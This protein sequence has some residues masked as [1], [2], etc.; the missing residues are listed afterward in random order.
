VSSPPLGVDLVSA[1][2]MTY[3]DEAIGIARAA[4]DVGIPAVISFDTGDP[5]ELAEH[6]ASLR[7]TLP[8]LTVFG[9]CCATDHRHI[10]ALAA[11]VS[12]P[13]SVPG[14]R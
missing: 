7:H 6:V 5:D 13:K 8:R 3:A 12:A 11:A 2:T 9:G 14:Q 1:I 10:A 4:D